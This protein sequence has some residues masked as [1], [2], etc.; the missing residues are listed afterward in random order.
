MGMG[1]SCGRSSVGAVGGVQ[2]KPN[3]HVVSSCYFCY[4][5]PCCRGGGKEVWKKVLQIG[6]GG[7]GCAEV[8]GEVTV[9]G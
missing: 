4:S 7:E 6:M 5:H 1:R 9:V 2:K 3:C 8:V